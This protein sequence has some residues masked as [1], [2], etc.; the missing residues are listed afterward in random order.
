MT[1]QL[2]EGGAGRNLLRAEEGGE[3]RS[4]TVCVEKGGGRGGSGS[5]PKQ[6]RCT[7]LTKSRTQEMIQ[8]NT[9]RTTPRTNRGNLVSN[10]TFLYKLHPFTNPHFMLSLV[11]QRFN[12]K[13]IW[14]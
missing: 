12:F 5:G 11:D 13:L 3:G 2:Q 14:N 9:H 6:N 1:S 8:S 4:Q 10:R 7:E